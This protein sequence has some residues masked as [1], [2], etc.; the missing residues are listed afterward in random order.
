MNGFKNKKF[1]NTIV[2]LMMEDIIVKVLQ[3]SKIMVDDYIK[4]GK[5]I[6]NHEEYIRNVLYNDYLNNTKI[7]REIGLD[8]FHF[9]AE[10][11]ENYQC[12]KPIGRVDLKVISEVTFTQKDAYFVIECKRIDGNNALNKAYVVDG[13]NRFLS[14]KGEKPKYSSYYGINCMLGMVVKSIDIDEN[15]EKINL[16][17]E[18]KTTVRSNASNIHKYN[19]NQNFIFTYIS[20]YKISDSKLKLYH[21]FYDYSSIIK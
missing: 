18:E 5:T 9:E 19:F 14:D 21:A 7:V 10:V 2:Q 1:N 16:I 13:I 8:K 3:C 11:P 17:H 20:D 12:Q 4:L 15:V 6:E